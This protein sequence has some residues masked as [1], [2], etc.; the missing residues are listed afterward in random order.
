MK[1]FLLFIFTVLMVS[2][3]VFAEVNS[4]DTKPYK[5]SINTVASNELK[6]PKLINITKTNAI[7]KKQYKQKIANDEKIYAVNKKKVDT[8]YYK[9]YRILEKI[10]RANNLYYQNWRFELKAETDDVNAYAHAA[11]LVT[12]YSSL[13][14]SL[15]D[16]DDAL[17]FILSHELSHLTLGHSQIHLEYLYKI[18]DLEII[19]VNASYGRYNQNTMAN[20]NSVYGNNYSALGNQLTSAVYLA[21]MASANNEI[22]KMY[23]K[24]RELEFDA[25]SEA[26]TMLLRAGYDPNN[27]MEAL[28]FM[29]NLPHVFTKKST[30]PVT[31]DRI[32]NVK[33]VLELSDIEELTNEGEKNILNS[34]V[35][36]IKKSPDKK[37]IIISKSKGNNHVTYAPKT[38]LDKV[39][40]KAYSYYIKK[41]MVSAERYFAKAYEM[42]P[43]SYI[44]PLYLS[45]IYE[46]K[47]YTNNDKI[48]L[49]NAAKWS[50]IATKIN[51][52]DANVIKQKNDIIADFKSLKSNKKIK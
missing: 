15:Y 45:Y 27:A 48:T 8:E 37:S 30:H 21:S 22:N 10:M 18:H 43:A 28:D 6:D 32:K 42:K 47:F 46:Y 24:L 31:S 39:L 26:I 14:D 52:T 51:P 40:E 5:L 4:N 12:M 36:D 41:D 29:S 20:I 9:L 3:C 33:E 25:D 19:F 49:K 23:A 38:K 13:Y 50:K 35:M 11:N 17:A 16:N 2:P 34:D 44:A 7:D 1:K